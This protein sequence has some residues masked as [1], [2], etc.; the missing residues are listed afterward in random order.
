MAAAVRPRIAA[1]NA[2]FLLWIVGW[3]SYLEGGL[4]GR[5]FAIP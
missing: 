5:A 3:R 2:S 4:G 1:E